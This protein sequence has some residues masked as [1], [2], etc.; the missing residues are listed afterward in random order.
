MQNKHVCVYIHIYN[1]YAY[2]YIYVKN[3]HTY[4]YMNADLFVRY[5]NKV[6]EAD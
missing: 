3:V 4:M 5:K 2:K 6:A 1:V